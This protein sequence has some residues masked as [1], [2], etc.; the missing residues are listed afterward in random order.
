MDRVQGI[1][2]KLA[3]GLPKHCRNSPLLAAL[4]IEKL[5]QLIKEHP[6]SLLRNSLIGN[7]K[8]RTFYTGMMTTYHKG[9]RDVNL[10]TRCK[11]I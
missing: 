7:S 3:M 5:E 9:N 8:A 1:L 4:G 11:T 10:L 6:L 2:I